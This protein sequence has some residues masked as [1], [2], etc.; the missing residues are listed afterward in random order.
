MGD[1]RRYLQIFLNFLSNSLKFTN[2]NGTITISVKVI[3]SQYASNS[4]RQNRNHQR[5]PQPKTSD[6]N[7]DRKL[8]K[9]ATT[10]NADKSEKNYWRRDSKRT[11]LNEKMF[12]NLQISIIDTGI[13]I[14]KEA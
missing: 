8:L 14:S 12:L 13:G 6:K 4:S 3:Q 2:R 5:Y 11:D 10:N 7:D 9:L 1:Q